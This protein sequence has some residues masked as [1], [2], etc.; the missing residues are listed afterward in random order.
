MV[1]MLHATSFSQT[2][3]EDKKTM[4]AVRAEG[5]IRI[6]GKL[7]ERDWQMA[8]PATDFTQFQFKWDVPSAFQTEVR[9][10]Y[11]NDALYVGAILHDHA[12]D[13]IRTQLTQRDDLGAVDFF[14]FAIDT[15]KDGINGFEFIVSASGVQLEAKVI[16]GGYEDVNWDA[17]WQ[18]ATFISDLGWVAEIKI[19]F[20]AIRFPNQEVQEWGI[21]FFREVNRNRDKSSWNRINPEIQGFIPH[22]G[23]LKGIEGIEAPMRLSLTPYLSGYYDNYNDKPNGISSNSVSY[24]GGADL[25]Y[26]LNDAFTLDMTLIPDFGQ[27]QS[28][29]QVLNLT[30]F[31]VY[32]VERRQFFTEGVELFEKG[33]LFYSRRIGGTPVGFYNAY[34][35]LAEGETV[36]E[37]PQNAQLLNA[38]KISG[39]TQSG[40]G[41]G[42]F[43]A[44]EGETYAT[45]EDVTGNNRGVLT[46]PRTNYNVVVFDQN[47]KNNSNIYI[48]NTNV[49]RSGSFDDA[50]VTAAGVSLRDKENMYGI[51]GDAKVSENFNTAENSPEMGYAHNLRFGKV[52]GNFQ[53]TGGYWFEGP[54][55][56]PNDLGFLQ[57]NNTVNY[58]V[59]TSYGHFE[60]F[61]VFNSVNV[62]AGANY[63]R[64]VEPDEFF[65]FSVYADAYAGFKN[66]LFAGIFFYSEPVITYDWF[67][68]RV[69]GRYYT[70]P[71]NHN[72]GGWVSTDYSK[73]LAMDVNFNYRWFAEEPERDIDGKRSRLN[74]YVAPRYRINDKMFVQFD[75]SAS[76]WPNDIGWADATED[77]IILGRRDVREYSSIVNLG[78]TPNVKMG[79][80]FRLRHYWSYAE[81]KQFYNL[82]DAGL[83]DP[84]S[85]NTFDG[86]G[87]SA[88]DVNFNAFNIDLVYTWFFAPGS[89]LNLVWK[90]AIYQFGSAIYTD[91]FDNM[92]Q[93][94]ES[95][96]NNNFSIKVIYFLDYLYL[97]KG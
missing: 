4:H 66:F 92:E 43:N 27:V 45:I 95:P 78:F 33:G 83:L 30:P 63:S 34:D 59:N 47:L 31:E 1:C 19:P 55:Y 96:V 86:N 15:Y 65:N 20:S 79:F 71:V 46:G 94:F 14:G 97:R 60:P 74:F 13:S 22:S 5:D 7:E 32:F 51:N 77:S 89:E 40:L 62:S 56:N 37:N 72:A 54:T 39:R 93:V 76:F 87:N 52:G 2:L 80:T 64:V 50:N 53:A 24:N 26:G 81:Y 57:I 44:I 49:L 67:E 8:M 61:L 42:L 18:S 23:I 10:M 73:K 68:P 9:V 12:P 48:I 85:Y 25:K 21:Q 6:D 3:L 16:E 84:S 38:T 36:S 41:I 69:P 91:Y 17:V 58:S 70:F 11:D 28:D 75:Q 90:N 82:S 29:N 35:N 88:N